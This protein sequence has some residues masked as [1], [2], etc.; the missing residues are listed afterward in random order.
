MALFQLHSVGFRF[1]DNIR[2]INEIKSRSMHYGAAFLCL[3]AVV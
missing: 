3:N 1:I 2:F